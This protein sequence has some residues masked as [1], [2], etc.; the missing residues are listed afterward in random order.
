[1]SCADRRTGHVQ[2]DEQ[3]L[4]LQ[5]LKGWLG[6]GQLGL[7]MPNRRMV[8]TVAQA[9]VE[10]A[11][12]QGLSLAALPICVP[13][14]ASPIAPSTRFEPRAP[15]EGWSSCVTGRR[16]LQAAPR[17]QTFPM[18]QVGLEPTASLVLSQ[19]GLPTCLP[20]RAQDRSRTCDR[21]GLADPR[22]SS[23][24]S[25]LRESNPP[26]RVGSPAPLPLGQGHTRRKV[27]ESNPQGSSLDRFRGGCHRR[28]A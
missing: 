18:A 16:A 5:I 6:Y 9:G 24:E 17:G 28:L 12:H 19:G 23:C 4:N 20:G 14:R 8:F 11:D 13:R 27:R 3:E 25:A 1:M 7:P 26:R 21:L 22:S 2:C 15:P 10:P